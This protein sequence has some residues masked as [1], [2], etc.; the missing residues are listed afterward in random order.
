MPRSV[1]WKAFLCLTGLTML[2]VAPSYAASLEVAPTTLR[3]EASSG[4]AVL[5][6]ANRGNEPIVVQI[7][8]FDWQQV[9]SSDELKPSDAVVVSP[10][11]ARIKPGEKQTVRLMVRPG[12][13]SGVERAFRVLASELP[14]P[15]LHDAQAVR[16]L[17]QFNIPL[18]VAT[19]A[20]APAQLS[21]DA[22]IHEQRLSLSAKN[23][24]SAH[25]KFAKLELVTPSGQRID[26]AAQGLS[27]VLPGAK[28]EWNVPSAG[29]HVGDRVLIE[30]RTEDSDAVIH[31]VVV[32]R[33]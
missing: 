32:I 22:E 21:W 27:Y 14:D 24:G 19:R 5:Q 18:F 7:E 25:L 30:A 20:A 28:H 29:L 11:M 16:V 13:A 9:G 1:R 17:L 23:N 3:I 31:G 6:L 4:V 8:G 12:G 10:P 15:A 26:A 2:A 33:P